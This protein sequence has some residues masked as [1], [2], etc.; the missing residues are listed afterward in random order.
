MK[1]SIMRWGVG[2]IAALVLVHATVSAAVFYVDSDAPGGG[3]GKSWAG[4][5]ADLGRALDVVIAGDE[6]R[7]AGGVYRPG[8]AG[9]NRSYSFFIGSPIR[10]IGGFAGAG[11]PDPDARDIAAYPTILSGDLNGD[12]AAVQ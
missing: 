4:A 11:Q 7:V 10:L 8:P 1:S 2:G 9:G 5:Y 12:D 3:D 6:V